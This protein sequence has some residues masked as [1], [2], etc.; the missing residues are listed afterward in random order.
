MGTKRNNLI[1]RLRRKGFLIDT[2]ARTIFVTDFKEADCPQVRRLRSIFNF[3][4]QLFF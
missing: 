1:Y 2:D 3:A 4:V